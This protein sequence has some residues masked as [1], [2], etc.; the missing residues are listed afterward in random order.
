MTPDSDQPPAKMTANDQHFEEV[1]RALREYGWGILLKDND[2]ELMNGAHLQGVERLRNLLVGV[3]NSEGRLHEAIDIKRAERWNDYRH[4]DVLLEFGKQ[5]EIAAVLNAK[6]PVWKGNFSPWQGTA[7]TPL[8]LKPPK[9]QGWESKFR[10]K[11]DRYRN[12][13]ALIYEGLRKAA[14][15]L[16]RRFPVT[17]NMQFNSA[18]EAGQAW[19]RREDCIEKPPRA[20]GFGEDA[21]G[22]QVEFKQRW[23]M[24]NLLELGTPHEI[25]TVIKANEFNRNSPGMEHKGMW[26]DLRKRGSKAGR[27]WPILEGYSVCVDY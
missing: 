5:N 2:K 11:G 16:S 22:R 8:P 6:W 23:A 10:L 27:E 17:E 19:S 3:R 15:G 1:R 24:K 26:E 20:A 25:N 12:A 9:E 4:L 7:M 21:Y 18:V 14:I 13:G